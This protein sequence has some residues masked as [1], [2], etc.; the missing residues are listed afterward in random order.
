LESHGKHCP[1]VEALYER[2]NPSLHER[3]IEGF[4]FEQE[5]Q[6]GSQTVG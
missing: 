1:F 3:H 6:P 5:T 2:T 4:W